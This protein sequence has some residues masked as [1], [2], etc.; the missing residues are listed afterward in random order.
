MAM[1]TPRRGMAK[2]KDKPDPTP[3]QAP[4]EYPPPDLEGPEP[5]LAHLAGGIALSM[6]AAVTMLPLYDYVD[7]H[8]WWDVW[9]RLH[10][11]K[12]SLTVKNDSLTTLRLV[13]FR[14]C[15]LCV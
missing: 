4:R 6:F 14:H 3:R 8:P 13:L 1:S 12:K 7:N 11:Q 9:V 5:G 10:D 2:S 15:I